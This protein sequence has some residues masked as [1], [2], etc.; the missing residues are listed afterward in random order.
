MPRWIKQLI[1]YII[2][3]VVYGLLINFKVAG[4]LLVGIA[5]HECGH[6][7][8][9]KY[10]GMKAKGF[11]LIPFLGG[12]ALIGDRYKKYTDQ[13]LVALA[14]PVAG[15]LLTFVFYVLSIITNSVFI[16]GAAY[17]M[18]WL[19]LCNLIP[20]ATLDGGQVMQSIVFSLN[21]KIGAIFLTISYIVAC[22]IIWHFNPIIVGFIIFIGIQ[23]VSD[24]WQ[25]VKLIDQGLEYFL[26]PHSV[27]MSMKQI[28]V[29]SFI[30]VSII[31]I[32]IV[33]MHLFIIHNIN[34]NNFLK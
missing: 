10:L 24:A 17:W 25:R 26:S 15:A 18:A 32:L 31:T 11:Y 29:V 6:L 5:F 19:N 23:Q 3:L 27:R 7:Y 13:A 21:E 34:M 33:L 16:G 9:A 2:S 4:L 14:G 1:S 20:L 28:V 30:Y 8:A 22:F 12:V